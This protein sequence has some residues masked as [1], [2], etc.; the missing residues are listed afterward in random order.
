[1]STSRIGLRRYT[2]SYLASTEYRRSSRLPSLS[3]QGDVG[4]AI[5]STSRINKQ[6]NICTIED[7]I[8]LEELH[9]VRA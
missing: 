6:T 2:R 8:P 5:I 7:F 1:L 4:R 9:R 3:F